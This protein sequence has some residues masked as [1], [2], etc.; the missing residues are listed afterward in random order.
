MG[1]ALAIGVPMFLQS[2]SRRRLVVSLAVAAGL[3]I[4]VG[5]AVRAAA[6]G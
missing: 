2:P 1:T 5:L 3:A 4:I 6:H